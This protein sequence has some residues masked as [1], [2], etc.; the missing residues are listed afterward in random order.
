MSGLNNLNK[1]LQYYGGNIEGRMNKDKLNALVKASK[2]AY[3][4]ETAILEDGRE[5]KCLINKDKTSE[6]KVGGLA[7]YS[8]EQVAVVRQMSEIAQKGYEYQQS[9][10][11][12]IIAAQEEAA[13]IAAE[14]AEK[15]AKIKERSETAKLKYGHRGPNHPVKD[16][17]DGRVHITS[18]NHG[19]YIVEESVNKD[20]AEVSHINLNDGTVEGLRYKNKDIF[21]VQFHPEACPGPEDTAYI[22]DEFI[23]LVKTNKK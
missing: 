18:Q 6:E 9:Q 5:F 19:Y 10:L 14:N 3:Q 1:R 7:G 21:T 8:S 16:L 11:Q 23:D 22:F 2:Y 20:I 13:K 12:N 4:A 17:K 15:I